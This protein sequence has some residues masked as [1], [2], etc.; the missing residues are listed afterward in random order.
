MSL[1]AANVH[2]HA[3]AAACPHGLPPGACPICSGMAGGNSTTKRDIP[4]NPGEMT[5]NQCAAIGAILKAQKHAKQQ[6]KI[7]E[8]S[9]QEALTNFQ[10]NITATRQRILQYASM[11]SNSMP[12]IIAKPIN[13]ILTAIVG[14]VLNIIRNLPMSVVN[15]INSFNA[16]FV[17][18]S[19][20]LAAVWGEFKNAVE[21]NISKFFS[22]IKQKFKL[23][24]V[25]GTQET[26]DE[27]KKIEEDK[28]TFEVKTFIHKLY[29]RLKNKQEKVTE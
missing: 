10:K 9:R 18:I 20:K 25:F 5:Y 2:N 19:D 12:P 27:E 21:E 7:A 14:N 15:I 29:R 22:K 11:I 17:D 6:A 3:K 8:Q 13:F 4:R 28:R 1:S 23:L 24:F 16:K 26:D